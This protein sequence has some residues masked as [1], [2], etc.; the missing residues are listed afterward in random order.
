M[1]SRIVAS[2]P[3]RLELWRFGDEHIKGYEPL[4]EQAFTEVYA[5]KKCPL[6]RYFDEV[7]V[8]HV[9]QYSYGE[10]IVVLVEKRGNKLSLTRTYQTFL[11]KLTLTGSPWEEISEE[12]LTEYATVIADTKN[13]LKSS[14]K[15]SRKSKKILKIISVIGVLIIALLITWSY[16][17]YQKYNQRVENQ[18]VTLKE[19]DSIKARLTGIQQGITSIRSSSSQVIIEPEQVKE[20]QVQLKEL[21][22]EVSRLDTTSGTAYLQKEILSVEKAINQSK[23]ELDMIEKYGLP[24]QIWRESILMR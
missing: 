21:K 23:N 2:E 14:E 18:D 16:Q 4:F 7:Q 11:E 17:S 1:P 8:Q 13:Q 6:G 3:K 12:S 20:M 22:S 9:P 19:I 5:L 24:D 10:E 15:A